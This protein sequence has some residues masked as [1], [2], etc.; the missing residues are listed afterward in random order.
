V[1]TQLMEGLKAS[2]Q[3]GLKSKTH[4]GSRQPATTN[5]TCWGSTGRLPGPD[6]LERGS[7]R[8]ISTVA[9]TLRRPGRHCNF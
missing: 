1:S 3:A 5:T 2:I 4:A 9:V 6:L 8:Y 7:R